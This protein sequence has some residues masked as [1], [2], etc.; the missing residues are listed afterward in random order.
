MTK[1]ADIMAKSA[2][3]ARLE[4]LR[5][6]YA[7]LLELCE[8]RDQ[9]L[10]AQAKQAQNSTSQLQ[11]E[12]PQGFGDGVLHSALRVQPQHFASS[13]TQSTSL[14]VPMSGKAEAA[15]EALTQA[16]APPCLA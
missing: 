3:I 10:A 6:A 1:S 12:R 11:D 4:E 9:I 5:E 7:R 13:V 15:Y 14:S 2:E 16:R 8:Q